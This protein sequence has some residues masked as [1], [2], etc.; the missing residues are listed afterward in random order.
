MAAIAELVAEVVDVERGIEDRDY[1]I[2]QLMKAICT[3]A[4]NT[5]I[6]GRPTMENPVAVA[7]VN[8]AL[9]LGEKALS[10]TRHFPIPYPGE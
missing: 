1:V 6:G 5:F 4:D 9:A 8:D 3:L 2:H 10:A 7:F